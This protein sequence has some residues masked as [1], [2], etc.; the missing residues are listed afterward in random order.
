MNTRILLTRLRAR[1]VNLEAEAASRRL[2]IDAPAGVLTD[3]LKASLVENKEALIES[4][5]RERAKLEAADERGLLI[6]YSKVPGY[7][8]LHDPTSGEW[9]DFP[10]SSCLPG[11]VESARAANRKRRAEKNGGAA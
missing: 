8:A 11:V 6:R 2:H 1:D 5:E 10:E 3:A 4:L 7:I 9:H